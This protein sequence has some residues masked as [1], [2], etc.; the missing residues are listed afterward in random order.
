MTDDLDHRLAALFQAGIPAPDRTFADRVV[1][2]AAHDHAVRIARRRAV[3]R[4][5]KETLALSATLAS[6]VLLARH[7][8]GTAG[9]GLGDSIALGSQAMLGILTLLL[10]GLAV[11]RPGAAA[12]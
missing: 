4:V 10:G 1:A 8:P 2:L 5:G 3:A 6:F 12:R 7:V 11:A 9:A